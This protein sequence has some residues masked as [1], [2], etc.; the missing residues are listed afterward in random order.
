MSRS[1][2]SVSFNAAILAFAALQSAASIQAQS[3]GAGVIV[4]PGYAGADAT[5]DGRWTHANTRTQVGP[6]RSLGQGLAVAAGP[7]GLSLSHSIGVDNHGVGL[8][9]NMNLSIGRGGAHISHGA[10][11]SI[12]GS[13]EVN[14]GGSATQGGWQPGLGWQPVG[15]GSTVGGVG[16]HVQTHTGARTFRFRRW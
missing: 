11:Q 16:N 5:A 13:T 2:A 1:Y 7:N 12:G 14:V 3:V 10:V 8:G 4:G 6:G 9:H 15:G